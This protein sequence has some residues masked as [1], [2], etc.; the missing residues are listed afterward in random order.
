MAQLRDLNKNLEIHDGKILII[1]D[2][3]GNIA[4]LERV[5]KSSGFK[6][7]KSIS[8]ARDAIDTFND[9]LPDLVLLDLNMP[10]FNGFQIMDQLKQAGKN[11]PD[12][13]LPVLIVTAQRDHP[14]RLRALDAGAKDFLTKPLEMTEAVTR[15]RNH[16]EMQLLHNQVIEQKRLLEEKVQERTQEVEATRMEIIHRLGRAAEYRDNETGMHV[17]RMSYLCERLG[18]E[19][20]M[21]ERE[22]KLLL[23]ASPLHDVGKIGIPDYIL[24]KPGKLTEAEYETMKLHPQIGAEI[25][26]G[27]TSELME[28]AR[29]I[30]LTH[31]ERWDGS[32]YPQGLKGEEIPLMGRIVALCDVFDALTSKRHYKEAYSLEKSWEIIE[33][34]KGTSFEDSLVET[35]EKILPEMLEITKKFSDAPEEEDAML[36]IFRTASAKYCDLPPTQKSPGFKH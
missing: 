17:V 13:Y 10:H 32:G 18:Q 21:P 7:V 35:F 3:P 11:D 30:A 27:G 31:Q 33:S 36:K 25:L 1:D 20:G 5:L 24:L 23:Y 14:T 28:M 15:I 6:N 26:S 16:L 8:D 2:E 29:I 12:Q 22:C 34:Q 4:V 19:L 9:F